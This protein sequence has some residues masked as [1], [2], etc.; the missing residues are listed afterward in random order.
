MFNLQLGCAIPQDLHCHMLKL[1]DG[2]ACIE[3]MTLATFASPPA[4]QTHLHALFA[5]D[6]L[7]SNDSF[8]P[9]IYFQQGSIASNPPPTQRSHPILRRCNDLV[10]PFDDATPKQH[11]FSHRIQGLFTS[12]SRQDHA[13]L[14]HYYRSG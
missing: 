5:I 7:D 3:A 9:L 10:Q 14:L 8:T 12:H 1:H 6:I 4:A 13:L 11:F 2:A